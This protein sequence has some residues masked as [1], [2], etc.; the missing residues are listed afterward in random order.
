V[1]ICLILRHKDITSSISESET[2][3]SGIT[4]PFDSYFNLRVNV[5]CINSSSVDSESDP[6]SD[7]ELQL[8]LE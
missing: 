2:A 7:P 5:C 8:D 1:Y 4:C 6:E 3:S